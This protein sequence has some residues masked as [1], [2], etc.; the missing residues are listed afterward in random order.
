MFAVKTGLVFVAAVLGGLAAGAA[1]GMLG[2]VL[3]SRSVFSPEDTVPVA[4]I[5]GAMIGASLAATSWG[6]LRYTP[7]R[8]V[9]IGPAAG[10]LLGGTAI[11]AIAGPF[12]DVG[13]IYGGLGG[14][15]AGFV[16]AV[17][18]L[19]RRYPAPEGTAPQAIGPGAV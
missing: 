15:V 18:G 11:G 16:V 12:S 19:Q 7:L 6:A 8:W 17:R 1:A 3:G 10:A 13:E 2:I 9:L 14:A 5:L 4:A